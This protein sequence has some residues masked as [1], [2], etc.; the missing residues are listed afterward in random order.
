MLD[1]RDILQLIDDRFND[2]P[3]A[4]QQFV[5]QR[6]QT[7]LHVALDAS[8][9]LHTSNKQ[10]LK[11]FLAD[12]TLVA[13]ELSEEFGREFLD[14]LAVIDIA[15]S[16]AESQQL[17]AVIGDQMQLESI[18]PTGGSLATLGQAFHNFVAEDAK[19]VANTKGS[20]INE[21]DTAA[22]GHASFQVAGQ[23]D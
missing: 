7:V 2:R 9:E 23:S 18:E 17:A 15:R 14:R 1:L 20:G 16:Q 6:H 12:V 19:I 5:H 21:A 8:D 3:L 4:Q 13:K 22:V 10:F 11:E